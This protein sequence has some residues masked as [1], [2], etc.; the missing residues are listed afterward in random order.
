MLH[1]KTKHDFDLIKRSPTHDYQRG[2]NIE[3]NGIEKLQGDF[4]IQTYNTSFRKKKTHIAF[5]WQDQKV[6]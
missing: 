5:P 4:L 1:I 2:E 6:D 3:K